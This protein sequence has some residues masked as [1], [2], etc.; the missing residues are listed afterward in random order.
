[1]YY[2]VNWHCHLEASKHDV[3]LYIPFFKSD[4]EEDILWSPNA[5]FVNVLNVVPIDLWTAVRGKLEHLKH[6]QSSAKLM[7][8]H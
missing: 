6:L 8:K 1:M 3:L 2:F 4:F 5:F 7:E